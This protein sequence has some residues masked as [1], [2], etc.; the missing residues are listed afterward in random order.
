MPQRQTALNPAQTAFAQK[1]FELYPTFLPTR[2]LYLDLEGSGRGIESIASFYWPRNPA[3][4]RFTWA[5][6]STTKPL[7]TDHFQTAV[8][9]LGLAG[10]EPRWVVVYSQGKYL[11]DERKRVVDLLGADPWPEAE[12]VNLLHAFQECR[13]MTDLIRENRNVKYFSDKTQIRRSLESL[14]WEFGIIRPPSIR[15]HN[16]QYSDGEIGEIRVL[17]LATKYISGSANQT[18]ANTL[19]YYCRQD[20]ESM[21]LIARRCERGLWTSKQRAVRYSQF[22]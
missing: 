3:S 7:D 15:S 4:S 16:N 10:T 6:R 20:V 9:A 11:S 18:Q 12:W 22:G 2:S 8:R 21:Q 5:V 14:E 1:L 17:D 13:E 19:G